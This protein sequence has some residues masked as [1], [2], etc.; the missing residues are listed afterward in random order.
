MNRVNR[1]PLSAA[2]IA[3]LVLALGSACG[4]G[5][6]PE[7]QSCSA[8]PECRAGLVCRADT[9]AVTLCKQPLAECALC[10]RTS[11]CQS[12]L[13]CNSFSD[14]SLRCGSGVGATTCATR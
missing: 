9:T 4:D 11:D 6:R 3:A 12:P 2:R 10:T 1:H 7:G 8:T 5:L 14:G 13:I